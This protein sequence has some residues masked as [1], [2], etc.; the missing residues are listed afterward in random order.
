MDLLVLEPSVKDQQIMHGAEVKQP[1][2]TGILF[3]WSK[4]PNDTAPLCNV[5]S[6]TGIEVTN[7]DDAVL[8][9]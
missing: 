6:N 3:S 4:T 9:W 7:N 8:L 5:H 2:A 1:D